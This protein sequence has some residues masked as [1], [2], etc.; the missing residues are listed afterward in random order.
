MP[1]YLPAPVWQSLDSRFALLGK[2]R[3]VGQDARTGPHRNRR[4]GERKDDTFLLCDEMVRRLFL[5]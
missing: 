2:E 5:T 1:L 4:A 3:V